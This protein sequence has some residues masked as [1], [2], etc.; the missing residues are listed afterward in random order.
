MECMA[1]FI[2]CTLVTWI[3]AE[4]INLTSSLHSFITVVQ[5]KTF[6]HRKCSQWYNICFFCRVG[7]MH[8]TSPL[9]SLKTE[10]PN[11][12]NLKMLY[13]AVGS[14]NLHGSLQMIFCTLHWLW[15][16][17]GEVHSFVHFTDQPATCGCMSMKEVASAK[18]LQ[19]R[20]TWS[21]RSKEIA[22]SSWIRCYET[23]DISGFLRACFPV[24]WDLYIT[25]WNYENG[26]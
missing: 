24:R 17:V 5:G 6:Y 2:L 7:V 19:S 9:F 16:D 20:N 8:F 4:L 13:T 15:K 10:Q 25:C 18:N 23:Y 1:T 26:F 11:E 3:H 22:W 21:G 12:I 14:L